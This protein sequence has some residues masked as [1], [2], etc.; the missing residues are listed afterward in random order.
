[1]Q[2]TPPR[3]VALDHVRA[4]AAFLVF[5]WHFAHGPFG[6]PVPFAQSPLLGILDEGHTGVALFM[7][8]S[9]YLFAKILEGRG[10]SYGKFL[11]RRAWRLLPLLGVV[12]LLVGVRVFAMGGELHRYALDLLYG[13]ALPTLPNGGWSITVEFHFYILL[14]LL[15]LALRRYPAALIG[16]LLLAIALRW[17]IYSATGAIQPI[18]YWTL[19]GRIDQFIGG[20]LAYRFRRAAQ[21]RHAFA[22]AASV[23]LAS[24]VLDFAGGFYGTRDS[25]LWVFIPTAEAVGFSVLIAYYDSTF[26]PRQSGISGFVGRIGVYSYSI[27]LLHFFFVFDAARFV[28]ENIVAFHTIYGAIPWAIASFLLMVPI[29]WASYTFIELPFLRRKRDYV[30]RD[31]DLERVGERAGQGIG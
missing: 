15:L 2:T 21:G 3:F 9:G 24:A 22:A 8:L 6:A 13:V 16:V 7:C 25:F 30:L 19:I 5:F 31:R 12:A 11:E 23:L 28:S 14:P 1:M 27:Y 18:G 4:L 20:M 26:T 10:I 17:A 29:A